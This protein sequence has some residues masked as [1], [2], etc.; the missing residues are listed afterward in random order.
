M[1]R[2]AST[3]GNNPQP[4]VLAKNRPSCHSI[5]RRV[6]QNT[7]GLC[8]STAKITHEKQR[9][10]H[11]HHP[12]RQPPQADR[13]SFHARC[14]I[15]RRARGSSHCRCQAHKAVAHAVSDRLNAGVGVI[16]TKANCVEHPRLTPTVCIR[17]SPQPTEIPPACWPAPIEDLT[18]QPAA[19][20]GNPA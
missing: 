5:H 15:S 10:T 7:P 20:M 8:L 9:I 18:R 13:L 11:P 17:S 6:A 2:A 12:H 4:S 19:T 1:I 14:R 3:H 16:D